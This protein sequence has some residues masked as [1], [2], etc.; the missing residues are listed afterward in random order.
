[1]TD[2]DAQA[3]HLLQLELDRRAHLNDLAREKVTDMDVSLGQFSPRN[4][5]LSH[6]T[7]GCV[8]GAEGHSEPAGRQ[9]FDRRDRGGGDH[10]MTKRGHRDAGPQ[11]QVCG[12]GDAGQGNPKIAVHRRRIIKP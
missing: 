11:V 9:I 4:R 6:G 8:A 1:M 5:I 10:G 2:R 3:Q 12:F 7:A